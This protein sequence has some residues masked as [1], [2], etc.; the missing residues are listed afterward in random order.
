MPHLIC[1]G[2]QRSATT[3][4][5]K[6]LR[7]T[8]ADITL[9]SVKEVHYFN[10]LWIP[11][12]R[13][14]CIQHRQRQVYESMQ[15]MISKASYKELSDSPINCARMLRLAMLF[16]SDVTDQWY[17]SFVMPAHNLSDRLS[18]DFT[19]EYALLSQDGFAHMQSLCPN[20]RYLFV[21]RDP[22][23]RAYSHLLKLNYDEGALLDV[24]SIASILHSNPDIIERSDYAE[25]LD[26]FT[27]SIDRGRL[28]VAIQDRIS[29]D[30]ETLFAETASFVGLPARDVDPNL[31]TT[32]EHVSL[33]QPIY[34]V[35]EI[36]VLKEIF[37]GHFSHCY[38]KLED[39][40]IATGY[41]W[42]AKAESFLD[43]LSSP[44][45]H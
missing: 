15:Y 36:Q 22:I 35:N 24:A 6:V 40:S 37:W 44:D 42:R 32:R 41:N 38:N 45:C 4:F 19:P 10:Q 12:Q 28:Q 2:A 7:D 25:T 21:L 3:W 27:S 30:P 16:S 14:W 29:V 31:L 34:S 26:V 23:E 5:Y 1:I 11:N 20:A 13:P 43:S 9:E 33:N 18:L 17:S 8:Y 39:R